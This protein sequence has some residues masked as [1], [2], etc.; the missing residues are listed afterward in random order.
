MLVLCAETEP[1]CMQRPPPSKLLS[2]WSTERSTEVIVPV[3]CSSC[4]RLSC[5]FDGVWLR[6]FEGEA[7]A[8]PLGARP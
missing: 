6:G 7:I 8:R 4:I 2:V 3:E 1:A 5:S